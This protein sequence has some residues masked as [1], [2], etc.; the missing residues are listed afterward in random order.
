M[1]KI[2][3]HANN[4]ILKLAKKCSNFNKGEVAMS[5][6]HEVER[7]PEHP[8]FPKTPELIPREET[9]EIKWRHG[10]YDEVLEEIRHEEYD[11]EKREHGVH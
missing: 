6:L 4:A 1:D 11:N 7:N 10:L 3:K 9:P 2:D 8:N 5:M